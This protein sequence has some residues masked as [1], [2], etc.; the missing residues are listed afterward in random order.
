MEDA[1]KYLMIVGFVVLAGV[2][3]AACPPING[4]YIMA[5]TE[6]HGA[7]TFCRARIV[8]KQLRARCERPFDSLTTQ[9]NGPVAQDGRCEISGDF[10][11][12]QGNRVVPLNLTRGFRARK[13][14]T[15]LGDIHDQPGNTVVFRFDRR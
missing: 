14:I 11:W 8:A 10:D 5:F 9:I 2:A 7:T 6:R 3:Q 4:R 13:A 12:V 1:M 15:G